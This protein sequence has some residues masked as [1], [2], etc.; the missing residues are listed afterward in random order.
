MDGEKDPAGRWTRGLRT[1][2]NAQKTE[3][4]VGSYIHLGLTLAASTLLFFYAGYKL[5][6][7]IGTLPIFALL[8]TFLGAFGGF[9]YLYRVLTAGERKKEKG[10][11]R[12]GV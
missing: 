11:D 2:K 10:P 5:D 8:G 4:T 3:A 12:D 6:R 9:L 1:L 7:W